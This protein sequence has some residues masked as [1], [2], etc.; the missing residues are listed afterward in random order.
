MNLLSAKW[1][2]NPPVLQQA[3]ENGHVGVSDGPQGRIYVVSKLCP[4]PDQVK[5]AIA[6]R[7]KLELAWA[8]S[9]GCGAVASIAWLAHLSNT[10]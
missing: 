2:P 5:R 6:L 9:L 4:N 1:M 8:G 10:G 3:I 7:N